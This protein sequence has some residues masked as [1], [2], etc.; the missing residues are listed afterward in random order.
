MNN[1]DL[2]LLESLAL[3]FFNPTGP[4]FALTNES[5]SNLIVSLCE[6]GRQ[7]VDPAGYLRHLIEVAETRRESAL[8]RA[9]SR[10]S[11]VQLPQRTLKVPLLTE[12]SAGEMF[13]DCRD[14]PW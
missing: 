10:G 13:G 6:R 4:K 14:H 8:D 12:Q 11:L 1:Q 7:D 3:A 2:S 5:A 9:R